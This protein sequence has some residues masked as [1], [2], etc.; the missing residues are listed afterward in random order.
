MSSKAE[1]PG[2]NL[3]ALLLF[4][5]ILVAGAW[6]FQEWVMKPAFRS[7]MVNL[8]APVEVQAEDHG[9]DKIVTDEF[10][11]DMSSGTGDEEFDYTKSSGDWVVSA[12]KLGEDPIII[13]PY[14]TFGVLSLFFGFV[15]AVILTAMVRKV[16]YIARKI[17][18]EI[19]HTINRIGV[20]SDTPLTR[21]PRMTNS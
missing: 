9:Q 1:N 10:I 15:I 13:Q 3:V 5:A 12:E 6:V 16:G 21:L 2:S 19:I 11:L 18:R 17:D 14:L 7:T 4:L 20:G 8:F